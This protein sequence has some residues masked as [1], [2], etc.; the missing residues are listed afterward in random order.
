MK[1]ITTLIVLLLVVVIGYTQSVGVGTTT[2]HASAML[3]ITSTNKGLLLPRISFANRPAS[4]ATGLVIYQT[5]NTPG[6]YCYTG[7]VWL[8]LGT[9]ISGTGSSGQVSYFNGSSSLTSSSSFLWDNS[10]SM[11]RVNGINDGTP[12]AGYSNWISGNFGGS[13][14]NRV[15][16]GVQNSD[17]TIGAHN[18]ALTNWAKLVINPGGVTAIGSLVGT[19]TR[20]VV[21]NAIGEVTT[22]AIPVTSG[23]TVSSVSAAS[24][25]GNPITVANTTST[26]TIDIPVATS[27]VNGYL[28]SNDWATFN[29]KQNPL[30]IANGSTNGILSST[31]WATF[32]SKQNTL[33]I[34]NGSTN[35]ILSSADWT[36]FNNKFTLPTLTNGSV[37]FSNGSTIAQNNNN[38]YWDNTAS[39][40]GINSTNNGTLAAGTI[41]WIAAHI[42]GTGGNRVVMG[43]QNGDATIGAHANALDAWAKLVINP[44]GVT[45]IG[46]LVGTGTRM[47][48]A[49]DNGEVSTQTVPAGADNLGNHTAAQS[50]NLATYKLVGN[51]GITGIAIGNNGTVTMDAG[52]NVV[53]STTLNTLAGTGNRMVVANTSGV[54]STQAIPT[55]G[56]NLGN[57]TATQSINLNNNWLSNNGTTTGLRVNNNGSVGV[58]IATPQGAFDVAKT[59]VGYSGNPGPNLYSSL[60]ATFFS[61]SNANST[62]AQNAFDNNVTTV[63][64]P[65]YIASY[66]PMF[67]GTD[68]GLGNSKVVRFMSMY[69][70]TLAVLP[71]Y[72]TSLNSG[73]RFNINLEGSND[74]LTYTQIF[75]SG[76]VTYNSFVTDFTYTTPIPSNTTPYRFLRV[77]FL[78]LEGFPDRVGWVEIAS[79]ANIKEIIFNEETNTNFYN[80][81]GFTV[82]ENG[83]VGVGTNSPTTNLD[84]VGSLRLRNGAANN[85]VLVSDANGNASWNANP[86]FTTANFTNSTITNGTI[87]N[88]T[89]TNGTITT[90]TITNGTITNATITNATT[91]NLGV[92]TAPTTNNSI[93]T[94]G[95]GGIK[96]SSTNSGTG[97]T[98]WIATNA[99]GTAGDR[100]VSGLLNGAATIGAHNNALAAWS[101]LVINPTNANTVT[102]GTS[103][104]ATPLIGGLSGNLN[105]NLIVNGSVRQ[106]Y[107]GASTGSI[108]ANNSV[109]LTWTHNLGYN[110]IVIASLDQTGGGSY[111]DFCTVTTNSPNANTTQFIIRN[112]GSNAAIGSI[113]W[114]L[115]W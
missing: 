41:N 74:G 94:S 77:R 17:A 30:S 23:G 45:S 10:L 85:A 32:N 88:G 5:D 50:I 105:R 35:G 97:A 100:V 55:S 14:G 27:T 93:T 95:T 67:C 80:S 115:V 38:F 111:M 91:T 64:S 65:S 109:T 54:L 52:L 12:A 113:R 2:P 103:A 78:S 47:V 112:L 98:D 79:G 24:T 16:I 68:Y 3:D 82:L 89:I 72:S 51:N 26:P 107:Y 57:H 92:G 31:D 7:S 6:I 42:G 108:A 76:L 114:I 20:M 101:D 110:P 8:M 13:G 48:V 34:A 39:R 37:L 11:L 63:W 33:S 53:G 71:G 21:A 46:S 81:G 86:T 61:S 19:G 9:G 104:N 96:V 83:N 29:S 102:I 49:N 36:S 15:I 62:N 70:S 73:L 90:G 44:G 4:P 66:L 22:Q 75:N 40:L 56:D 60:G 59:T 106:G 28:S 25:S 69:I 18:N 84:V 99:G 43:V 1:K 58:N 87:T